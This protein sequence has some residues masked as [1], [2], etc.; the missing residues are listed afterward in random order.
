MSP[1]AKA[2]VASV[3]ATSVA[4]TALAEGGYSGEARAVIALLAWTA[5]LSGLLY[6]LFPRSRPP[7]AALVIGLLL[8]GLAAFTLVSVA[9]AS[10]N[11]A[12][13]QQF[14]KVGGYLGLFALVVLASREGELRPWIGGLAAGI[15]AVAAMAVLSRLV[16]AL[17]GGDEEII[18]QLP[19]AHGRLS[20]PIGYW[21]GLA[22]LLAI[23]LTLLAWFGAFAQTRVGRACATGTIPLLALGIYLTSSRGG[24]AA[25]VAGLLV[26][27]LLGP[28][29]PALGMTGVLAALGSGVAILIARGEPALLDP[30][31]GDVGTGAG[32]GVLAAT[33]GCMLITGAARGWFDYL[34]P[35]HIRIP[36]SRVAAGVS[37]ALVLIA[38][39]AIDP[40]QRFD[41]F[42]E[43]P[44]APDGNDFISAHL[45]SGS[46]SGRWQYWQEA[47]DAY[48][49]EPL[50]GLGAGGYGDYWNQ[51]AP[52]DLT[53]THAHSLYLE[54]LADLGLLGL[55][56]VL[57]PLAIGGLRGVLDRR[58]FGDPDAIAALAALVATGAVSAAVDWTWDL[59]AVFGPVVVALGLLC[60]PAPVLA[61]SRALGGR[62]KRPA[63]LGRGWAIGVIVIGSF[64]LLVAADAFLADRNLERSRAAAADGDLQG[65]ADDARAAIALEPWASEPRLQLALV[66]ESAADFPEANE[67]IREAIERSPDD[68]H[69][70]LV[71]A[72]IATLDSNLDEANEA[73]D[74]ARSLN[75]RGPVFTDLT[76]PLGP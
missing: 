28:R 73:F 75:P 50:H 7:D 30:T 47:L 70:W 37:A 68:W 8:A 55:L 17:P 24:L 56:L 62:V 46:S 74:R 19:A 42:K 71:R 51:H 43:P 59:P 69:L 31:D 32:L 53:V 35:P 41:E 60:G 33:L 39:L 65:A 66:Q 38:L 4:L 2:L 27:V 23:G 34:P 67:T 14:I 15:T 63:R 21:N 76:G 72:R 1:R 22:A 45:T 52:I 11:G 49:S 58:S 36:Q 25:L 10:D 16:P 40:I 13:V 57:G 44:R 9:W 54:Q 20:Y 3:V 29:R 48:G 12:V 64:T 5:V 26:L 61:A 6:G 18:R